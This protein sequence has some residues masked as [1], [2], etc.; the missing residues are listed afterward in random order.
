MPKCPFK[1]VTGLQCPGCGLQRALHALLQGRFLDA[2]HY[3]YFFVFAGPYIFLFEVRALLPQGE[4]KN[5]V[6][7][8]IEDRRLIWLYIILFFVWLVVRNIL[9]I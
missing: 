2:I 5:E 7:K 8:I 9:H 1:L 3:N 4:L 6:T